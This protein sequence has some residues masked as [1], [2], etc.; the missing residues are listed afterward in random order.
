MLGIY[1]VVGALHCS[2]GPNSE[3]CR[4]VGAC[5]PGRIVRHLASS[6]HGVLGPHLA[7]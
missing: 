6:Q 4:H 2:R 1:I 7:F 5:N 3:V